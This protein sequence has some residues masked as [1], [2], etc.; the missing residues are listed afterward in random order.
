MHVE[1]RGQ[2]AEVSSPVGLNLNSDC[3]VGGKH[4]LLSHLLGPSSRF[5]SDYN[6]L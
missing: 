6:P 3:Q 1:V 2:P 4:S 5:N